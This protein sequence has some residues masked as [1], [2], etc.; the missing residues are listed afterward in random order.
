LIAGI[1]ACG[2]VF[3]LQGGGLIGTPNPPS[4]LETALVAASASNALPEN[5]PPAPPVSVEVPRIVI[6][7]SSA[8]PPSP[9]RSPKHGVT[10]DDGIA[11]PFCERRTTEL[12]TGVVICDRNA[13]TRTS[14]EPDYKRS[15]ALVDYSADA[16]RSF[17]IGE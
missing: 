12:G 17:T 3:F 14:N 5:P 4:A 16:S 13:H 7:V 10:S 8:T 15:G 2:F 6:A 11:R 1:A 9:K